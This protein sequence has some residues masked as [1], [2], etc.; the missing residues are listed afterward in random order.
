M[1]SSNYLRGVQLFELGRFEEAKRYFQEDLENWDSRYYLAYC[2]FNTDDASGAE[3]IVNELISEQ[4][5][6]DSLFFLK[7]RIAVHKSDYKKAEMYIDEAIAMDPYHA[8]Y[9]GFKA[10]IAMLRKLHKLALKSANEGLAIDPKNSLCLNTR[11]QA[12]TKL[13]RIDEAD[14]TVE[15]ILFEN[16]ED[17]YSHANVGWVALEN[18][19]RKEALNHFKEALK[20]NPNF[21]YARQGMTT[22]LKSKN[23]IYSWYMKY[24]FWISKQSSRNQWGFIIGVYLIYRFSLK[25]LSASGLSYLA[26]PLIILYM[27]FALGGWIMEPLSNTILNFD[28]YGKYLLS[29]EQRLS[30]YTFGG[31]LGIALIALIIFYITNLPY[32]MILSIGFLCA[33]IPLPRAFLLDSKK[34]KFVGIGVG[35]LMLLVGIF[36]FFI[37]TNTYPLIAIIVG[38]LIVYTWVGNAFD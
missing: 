30:G 25:F 32:F 37:T 33:L 16:P 13:K 27:L 9:F 18:G 3:Q 29:K 1:E 12:L 17:S 31:L 14:Q 34:G 11:A 8:D 38:A 20:S 5:N 10:H 7:S 6:E 22:A 26:I 23:P 2:L 19:K 4:P 24:A 35:I 15:D 21:E 28:S 36:G